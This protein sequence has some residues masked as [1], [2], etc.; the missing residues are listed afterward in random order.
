MTEIH[1]KPVVD[2]VKMPKIKINK[3]K[4]AQLNAWSIALAVFLG[5]SAIFAAIAGF[6]RGD[7]SFSIPFFGRFMGSNAGVPTIL[8]TALFALIFGIIGI[9]TL[10]KVTD[11]EATRAAWGCISKVF[12]AFMF[13]Y[14]VDMIGVVLYSLMSLGR[15][16]DLTFDQGTLW[17]CS[18][19]PTVI[20]FIGAAAIWFI[21]KQI[22]EGKTTF[23]RIASL[24]AIGIASVAFVL[25]FIQQLVS[26]YS[27]PK[28]SLDRVK[29]SDYSK[30]FYPFDD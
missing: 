3:Q 15:A 30:L 13:I 21:G 10:K 26:Y 23:L 4:I 14:I 12:F 22:S 24:V 8:L 27:K 1:E 25:V 9:V 16:D 19:L 7:W 20:C 11:V 29:D 6:T 18:F 28:S 2:P 5:W 17:L